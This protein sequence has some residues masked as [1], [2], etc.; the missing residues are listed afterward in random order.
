MVP[1]R[2]EHSNDLRSLIIKRF[3]NGDSEQEIAT[4]TLFP[5]ETVRDIIDKYKRNKCIQNLF[6]RGR[7]RKPTTTTARTI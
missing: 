4:K 1:K 7:K 5:R 3:Q 6:G 2:E